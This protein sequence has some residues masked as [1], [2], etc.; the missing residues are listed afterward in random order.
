MTAARYC[1]WNSSP[2]LIFPPWSTFANTPFVGMMH[3]PIFWKIRHPWWHSFPICVIS[4]ITSRHISRV[5]TGKE[6]KSKFVTTRFSPKAPS[7]TSAPFARN[8]SK[9]P[10]V[11]SA[12][13]ALNAAIVSSDNKEICLCQFPAWASPSMPQFSTNTADSIFFFCVPR[14]SLMHTALTFPI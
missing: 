13:R 11:T 10:S 14:F 3:S 4:K 8:A 5:P 1:T 2:T 9:A 12:P 7:I 6:R